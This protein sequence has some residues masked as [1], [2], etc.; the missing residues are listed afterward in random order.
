M[1]SVD[2]YGPTESGPSGYRRGD[3]ASYC[4]VAV[5][6]VIAGSMSDTRAPGIR[7]AL[8]VGLVTLWVV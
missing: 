8:A 3:H 6:G 5:L 4:I 7:E 2:G 1:G